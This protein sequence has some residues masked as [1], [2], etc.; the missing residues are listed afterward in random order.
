MTFIIKYFCQNIANDSISKVNISLIKGINY[1]NQKQLT[2][3]QIH[4]EKYIN[5]KKILF[6]NESISYLLVIYFKKDDYQKG[7]DLISYFEGSFES[8]SN[9]RVY[10][11][12]IKNIFLFFKFQSEELKQKI[13]NDFKQFKNSKNNNKFALFIFWFL[14]QFYQK[15][16]DSKT[17]LELQSQ[18]LLLI[19]SIS[20]QISGLQLKNIF[21]EKPL[22]HQML[23]EELEFNF[24]SENDNGD[25]IDDTIKIKNEIFKFCTNC[26]FNNI[27]SFSFCPSCGQKLT[28]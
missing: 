4:L 2:D 23:N 10:F 11:F 25:F 13:I 18:A 3:S 15:I 9:N 20:N 17:S 19:E 1:F 27:K 12:L 5:S 7:L 24:I 28:K 26:G 21:V 22:L 8:G 6:L 16:N 14:I